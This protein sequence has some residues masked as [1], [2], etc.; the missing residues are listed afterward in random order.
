MKIQP[1]GKVPVL[2]DEGLIMFESR[3]ICRYLAR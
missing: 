3:A 1:F 2:D